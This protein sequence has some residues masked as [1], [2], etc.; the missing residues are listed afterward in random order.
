MLAPGQLVHAQAQSADVQFPL[1]SRLGL[2]P[3]TGLTLSAAFPGFE[4][5]AN[6][7]YIRLISLP[8]KAFAEIE[9]TMTNDALKKQ[10]MTV[11]K[12]ETPALPS[13]KSL[14]VIARQDTSAGRI[15]KWLLIAPIADLTAMISYEVL[16][17][18]K[19]TYPDAAIRAALTSVTARATV[20]V[21]E[22]LALVPFKLG[23]LGGLRVVGIIPGRAVQ[24]TDGPKDTVDTIDQAH[25]VIGAAPGGPQHAS[26]RD[27]FARSALGGLPNLKDVRIIGSETMRIGGLQGHEIRAEGK[28]PQTGAD[29]EIVQWIRF[30]SGGYMRF[31]GFGPK[32]TW[33]QTFAR[34]RQVRDGLEPR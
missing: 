8:D 3:P 2:Q 13:G 22:Q 16:D 25:L 29:V 28:D 32:D 18:T 10:G 24:L 7:A 33:T 12:R 34:F 4:D 30:G 31:L 15:R 26:D 5:R 9:K 20:P 6:G 14:L 19:S 11:E 21:E 1:G 27:S 23:D 17:T